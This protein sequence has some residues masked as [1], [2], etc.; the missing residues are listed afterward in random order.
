MTPPL[1]SLLVAHLELLHRYSNPSPSL[2]PKILKL[3]KKYTSRAPNSSE[4]WL[5]RL[6]FEDLYSDGSSWHKVWEEGRKS[7]GK[8]E[9]DS[10]SVEHVWLWGLKKID[11]S[12]VESQYI[13]EVSILNRAMYNYS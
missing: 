10:G 4:L 5:A 1:P 6:Q 2:A 7:I 11:E 8:N 12:N 13:Y 3:A 9:A